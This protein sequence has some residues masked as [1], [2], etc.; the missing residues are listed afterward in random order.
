LT[1]DTQTIVKRSWA[2][3]ISLPSDNAKVNRRLRANQNL[4]LTGLMVIYYHRHIKKYNEEKPQNIS[5]F[6]CQVFMLVSHTPQADK[7]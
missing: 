3:A 4:Q 7:E 2:I 1:Q 6:V 5:V